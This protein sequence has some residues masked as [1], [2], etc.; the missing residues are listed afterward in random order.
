MPND[1]KNTEFPKYAE[2]LSGGGRKRI[3]GEHT[4]RHQYA[5]PGKG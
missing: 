4:C 5:L 2:P 1:Q 3:S